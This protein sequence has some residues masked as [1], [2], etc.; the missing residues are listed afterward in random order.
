MFAYLR[1][2]FLIA[3]AISIGSGAFAS[4]L[5]AP[6]GAVILS[7]S[8][9]IEQTNQEGVAEF[10]RD[11]LTELDWTTIESYT[12]WT[13]GPKKF[14]GVPLATLLDAVGANG[15]ELVATALNDYSVKIPVADAEEHDVLLALEMDGEQ[16]RIR[17]KGP[18]WVIYPQSEAEAA[19]P[20]F[21]EKMIWQLKSLEITR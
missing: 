4:M 21:D 20:E 11:M 3:V 17:D 8:G 18:I 7:V 12:T 6:T 5:K 2:T 1:R 9:A 19:E 16:M 13:E 10:D 15:T 14:T